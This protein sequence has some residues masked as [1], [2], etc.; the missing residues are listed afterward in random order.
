MATKALALS[1]L[2]W[3]AACGGAEEPAAPLPEG[4]ANRQQAP[5]RR[6]LGGTT[7]TATASTINSVP[8]GTELM[9]WAERAYPQFFPG[10]QADIS[11]DPYLYRFYPATGNYVGVAGVDVYILGPVA[12]G[13]LL[14]V[15]AIGDFAALVWATRLAASD[16]AAARFLQQAQ[17]SSTRAE[18]ADVRS[19][20]YEAWLDAQMAL[21]V[22][23]LAW[24]WMAAQGFA[25]VDAHAYYDAGAPTVDNF[26]HHDFMTAPDTVRKRAALALSEYFVVSALVGIP[27]TNM[28][29]AHY[30]DQLNANAFGNFRQLLE[31]MTLNPAMGAWLN[32]RG[33]QKEDAASGRLPDENYAREVMQLFTIGLV[34]LQSD[35]TPELDAKGQPIPCYAQDDVS[36]L[37]R[38]FTGYDDWDDGRRFIA[39]ATN[40]TRPYPE[41]TRRALVLDASKHSNLAVRF[42]GTTIAASTP[43]AAA[44]KKALDA[45]FQHP[46]V[47]PFF[48][49]Q[50]I[51]RLVTSH[52]SPAYVARVAAKF[53]DNGAGVRGDLKAVWKAILLDEE[54]RGAAGLA[55]STHGKLREPMLRV[56]QWERTFHVQPVG[57]Q[58]GLSFNFE[59]P[60]T[61]FGQRLLWAP[62]VF[63]FF[64]P[65]Y[66]PPGTAMAANGA[67]A[68]E[69]QVINE[70][71]TSQ[72]VN[73]V[74]N[75]NYASTLES[76]WWN[77][78]TGFADEVPLATNVPALLQHLNLLLCA[79]QL[80][81][82]TLQRLVTILTLPGLPVLSAGSPTDLKRY[83]VMAAI[84]MVMACP[85]YL[86][87]K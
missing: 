7:L 68:P 3:L 87:Q 42:I 27:W 5:T 40:N 30:W 65:G 58:W 39:P 28:A 52:P 36:Q 32:T 57:G 48:G 34:R 47:G 83:R 21:P 64:R 84:T 63:N 66:V 78:A 33:N 45:L 77:L 86:V 81:A 67:T 74:D 11:A 70:S 60:N 19:L 31:D 1:S 4:F 41:Y 37:A 69:F 12:G 76:P 79:G 18:I 16:E 44:L 82:G 75:M 62:S 10:H 46:N 61:W 20:G 72:W 54:A 35:G 85:E 59:D 71:S 73:F 2:A 49:R 53:N 8:T 9:D 25:T 56:L 6:V 23:E 13:S 29:M 22:G 26:L 14:R 55:S 15:G 50:M 17:L 24:D 43:A 80:S 51:Q 38:V